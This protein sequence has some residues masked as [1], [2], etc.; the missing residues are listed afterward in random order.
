MFVLMKILLSFLE[1]TLLIFGVDES[2]QIIDSSHKFNS[3]N[4]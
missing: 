3:E 1:K 2:K 4:A